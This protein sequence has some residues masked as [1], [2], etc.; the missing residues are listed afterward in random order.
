MIFHTSSRARFNGRLRSR[1]SAVI[2]LI[3][4][5][6]GGA[7]LSAIAAVWSPFALLPCVLCSIG[8]AFA[9]RYI[10]GITAGRAKKANVAGHGANPSH[11][12]DKA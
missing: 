8:L 11:A 7:L 10:R 5:L 1:D 12:S 4:T 3:Q 9:L 2:L 6:I